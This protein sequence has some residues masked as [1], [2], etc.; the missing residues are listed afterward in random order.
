MTAQDADERPT[1]SEIREVVNSIAWKNVISKSEDDRYLKILNEY[2]DKFYSTFYNIKYKYGD[3]NS[4]D[5]NEVIKRIA[6]KSKPKLK[7]N[8]DIFMGKVRMRDELLVKDDVK[9]EMGKILENFQANEQQL[10]LIKKTRAKS[11]KTHPIN[12]KEYLD[13]AKKLL[14]GE[15]DQEDYQK[16]MIHDNSA[17]LI[18]KM[19]HDDYTNSETLKILIM[20]LF[21]KLLECFNLNDKEIIVMNDELF[22]Q[23]VI[24]QEAVFDAIRMLLMK[25]KFEID[26][27]QQLDHY[28]RKEYEFFF[29]DFENDEELVIPNDLENFKLI[30]KYHGDSALFDTLAFLNYRVSHYSIFIRALTMINYFRHRE[31]FRFYCE[32][33][34]QSYNSNMLIIL[35]ISELKESIT[36]KFN[37]GEIKLIEEDSV[38]LAIHLGI[39]R[40]IRICKLNEEN[41]I[42][43]YCINR[44]TDELG[45]SMLKEPIYLLVDSESNDFYALKMIEER[46]NISLKIVPE[47]EMLDIFKEANNVQDNFYDIL[48]KLSGNYIN[49]MI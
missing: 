7:L 44:L 35:A 19:I 17:N 5:V 37:L 30:K 25:H 28:Q 32:I 26:Q 6:K 47:H 3:K 9:K 41:I 20:R 38:I 46:D 18:L 10:E 27:F 24:Q 22:E 42:S 49:Q 14:P 33:Y 16:F 31:S 13:D 23:H 2:H 48:W 4:I 36:N 39:Q 34:E 12:Y 43:E 8:K 11:R 15:I 21:K 1:C 29:L 45:T 40:V